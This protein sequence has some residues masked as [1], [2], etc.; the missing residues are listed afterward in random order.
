MRRSLRGILAIARLAFTASWTLSLSLMTIIIVAA[1]SM[2]AVAVALKLLVDAA[3]SHSLARGL[4]GGFVAAVVLMASVLWLPIGAGMSLTL[5]E[6]IGG[7][8]DRV[9]MNL[10]SQV[11]T[12]KLHDR[13][14]Y[15][16]RLEL[17]TSDD[18][19][20][21][22]TAVV[23][24]TGTVA[25]SALLIAV[26][27]V[28]GLQRPVL[29]VMPLFVIPVLWAA[30]AGDSGVEHARAETAPDQQLETAIFQ[31]GTASGSGKE[32]RVFGLRDELLAR[33]RRAEN[34]VRSALCR[35]GWRAAVLRTASWLLFAAA[36]IGTV[37]IV[38]DRAVHRQATPGDV[39]LA[40]SLVL[41]VVM[42]AG[43]V[44]KYLQMLTRLS[45][46]AQRLEWLRE[47]TS[48]P[49][50]RPVLPVPATLSEGIR[51]EGVTFGY[52]GGA[53]PVLADVDLLLPA[54]SVVALVGDNGAGKTT[55][56]KL[57]TRMYEPAAGRITVDGTSLGDFPM[58]EWRERICAGFQD[59]VRFE[60]L[61]RET[62]G[63]GDLPRIEEP[64]AVDAALTRSGGSRVLAGL[65]ANGETQL[66]RTWTDGV[67]I[68]EGQWQ[69]LAL[70]RAFMRERPLLSVLDEPTAALDPAAEQRLY[71]RFAS[72]S[73]ANSSQ[74]CVTVLVSHR[75]ST[76]RMADLIVVL[77]KGRVQQRGTHAEL[78]AQGG[79]YAELFELQASAYK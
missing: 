72:L 68:S 42:L 52:D 64:L 11:P 25:Y 4:A 26:A 70:G 2:F 1:F 37:L 32:L 17:L 78:I 51:L 79:L 20:A 53:E 38:V 7:A 12:L 27:V 65:P 16:A 24:V 5:Q 59:F 77:D 69:T 76:V 35:S 3:V 31:L 39:A 30:V 58:A 63:V 47:M 57:L 13:S 66:G 9:L 6:R 15:A 34:A 28:L 36:Y 45:A 41:P 62:V 56:V 75:F 19:F 46:A 29:A 21:M 71:E 14:E 10:V 61:A 55:L 54:G 43:N 67:E 50:D 44:T 40:V 48:V 22:N 49:P 18:R 73:R 74:G 60:L 8:V 33:H 23:T